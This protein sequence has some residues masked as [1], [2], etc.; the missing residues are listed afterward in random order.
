M[1]EIEHLK[2]KVAA[3]NAAL[4]EW[5]TK[6]NQLDATLKEAESQNANLV[7]QKKK[8]GNQAEVLKAE[9]GSSESKI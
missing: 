3:Q 6:Y 7:E 9:L 2:Q 5:E 1:Q 4:S 8:L